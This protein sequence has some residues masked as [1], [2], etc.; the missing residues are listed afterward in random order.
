[1]SHKGRPNRERHT[2]APEASGPA[3][4]HVLI[5]I[6]AVAGL[7]MLVLLGYI[8][9]CELRGELAFARFC[10]LQKLTA[11]TGYPQAIENAMQN[12][13]AEADRIMFYS[14]DNYDALWEIA[15]GCLK[16]TENDELDPVLRLRMGE[17]AVQAALLAGC[18]AP[19]DFESWVWLA[20]THAALGLWEQ[21]RLCLERAR[22]LAPRGMKI[23][24]LPA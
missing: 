24:L 11:R 1:M 10:Q 23:E 6:A 21:S 2:P 20:R 3:R 12:G 18:A 8:Q 5:R 15:L 19:S 7:V 16:W 13:F 17:K 14:G 9:L 22:E 4:Q